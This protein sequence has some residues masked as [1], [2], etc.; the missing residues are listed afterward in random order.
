MLLTWEKGLRG[1]CVC[2]LRSPSPTQQTQSRKGSPEQI[3]LKGEPESLE[4]MPC[5]RLADLT[6]HFVLFS[7]VHDTPSLVCHLLGARGQREQSLTPGNLG[8]CPGGNTAAK[9]FACALP[10]QEGTQLSCPGSRPLNCLGRAC[11]LG[12]GFFL[13][14]PSLRATFHYL[15]LLPPTAKHW[16][17]SPSLG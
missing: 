8:F 13:W 4:N 3:L 14:D 1:W 15:G 10:I 2:P 7:H 11:R 9:A 16:F 12:R 17:P 5:Y 6:H